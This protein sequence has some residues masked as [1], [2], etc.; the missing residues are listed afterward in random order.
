MKILA[1]P[2]QLHLKVE[3][4]MSRLEQLEAKFV[5]EEE[6]FKWLDKLFL[7]EMKSKRAAEQRMKKYEAQNRK[8]WQIDVGNL[9]LLRITILVLFMKN[10][11]MFDLY[12]GR[13]VCIEK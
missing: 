6:R 9:D 2:G 12:C 8:I 10:K 3:K 13:C 11:D 4:L 1:Y 7:A 5:S